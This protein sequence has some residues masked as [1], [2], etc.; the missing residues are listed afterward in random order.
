L[1]STRLVE[2][3]QADARIFHDHAE[4]LDLAPRLL[5]DADALAELSLDALD[6]VR[7]VGAD[8]D[9]D[10][11]AAGGPRRRRWLVLVQLLEERLDL[12]RPRHLLRDERG[13]ARHERVGFLDRHHPGVRHGRSQR[14]NASLKGSGGRGV[15]RLVP[16]H[17][18]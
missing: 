9:V 2:V 12:A 17:R 1:P 15:K 5:V 6:L 7:V 18:A 3:T 14:H 8:L 4:R 11:A 10:G 13:Q 16:V